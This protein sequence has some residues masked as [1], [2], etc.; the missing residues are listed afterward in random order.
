MFWLRQR[1]KRLDNVPSVER[2]YSY[3][4]SMCDVLDESYN[5]RARSGDGERVYLR[6]KAVR[7]VCENG[8]TNLEISIRSWYC[9]ATDRYNALQDRVAANGDRERREE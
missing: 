2:A 4:A 8:A 5:V 7:S 3:T 6:S 1:G 9:F